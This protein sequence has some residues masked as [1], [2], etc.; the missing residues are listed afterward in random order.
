[1]AMVMRK[2]G[3]PEEE[4][5]YRRL[6]RDFTEK[7]PS[8]YRQLNAA[9]LSAFQGD[10]QEA[11]TRLEAFAAEEN[12]A[13]WILLFLDVD[14]LLEDLWALPEFQKTARK[15]EDKFWTRHERLRRS[16]QEQNLL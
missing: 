1:M 10:Q 15:L 5:K 14:P 3:L 8:I 7:D 11:L 12:Y 4:E 2:M 13:Y 16:L 9:M 6:F